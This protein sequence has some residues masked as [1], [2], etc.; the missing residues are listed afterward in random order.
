M[1]QFD[2]LA[3]LTKS[4]D[5]YSSINEMSGRAASA[6]QWYTSDHN[7][8]LTPVNRLGLLD[9]QTAPKGDNLIDALCKLLQQ[10]MSL[11]TDETDLVLLHHSLVARW[12]D[13]SRERIT[14]SL[15]E[16]VLAC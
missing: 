2:V 1:E 16:Y 3:G 13:G 5:P 12:K 14:L 9:K 4:K 8:A 7:C 15:V 6:F 10:K 11:E